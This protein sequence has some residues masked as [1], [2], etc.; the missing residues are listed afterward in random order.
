L[1]EP[2]AGAFQEIRQLIRAPFAARR[3]HAHQEM[4]RV[5]EVAT[6][7]APE[8]GLDYDELRVG[9]HRPPHGAQQVDGA[10]VV[11]VVDDRE[12]Q[13]AVAAAGNMVEEVPALDRAPGR[14]GSAP[15]TLAGAG[16]HVGKIEQHRVK[17]GLRGEQVLE[18]RIGTTADTKSKNSS[19][20]AASTPLRPSRTIE[21]ARRHAAQNQSLD[22]KSTH[23]RHEPGW[24][25]RNRFVT[26]FARYRCDR[27]R[28]RNPHPAA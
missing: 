13:I 25:L 15:Q 4:A 10:V 6:W 9:L 17:A 12:A 2:Q 28:A 20:K 7:A 18:R 22:A 1:R 23:P 3:Q 16:D 19:P 5:G 27:S 11:P 8:H 26:P 21:S 24:S 14:E